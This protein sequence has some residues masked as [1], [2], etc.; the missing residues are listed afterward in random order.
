MTYNIECCRSVPE[1]SQKNQAAEPI[2]VEDRR[3]ASLVLVKLAQKDAFEEEVRTLSRDKL[4]SSHQLFQL[5]P[6]LQDGVLRVG[7]R[8]KRASLS[9]EERVWSHVW[10]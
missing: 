10:S 9:Y 8:L 6:V 3:K 5:D 7:G 4:P 1:T 2:N